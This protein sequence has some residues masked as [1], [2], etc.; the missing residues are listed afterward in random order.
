MLLSELFRSFVPLRNPIGFG[1]SD[2]VELVFA[3]LLVL[4]ALAWRPWIEPH[5]ARLAQRAGWCMLALAALPVVLRLLLLPQHPLPLPQISD[6]FSHLL[7]ADTLRHFRLANSTHPLHQFFETLDVLQEPSYGSIYPI[8]QGAVLALGWMIFGHPWAGAMLSVAAFCALCY[9]MLRG[10]TTPGWA[11]AGGLLA[12]FE[13]GPLNEWM[14]GYWG[15]G[16]SAAAGCLVFGAMPRLLEGKPLESKLG[17]RCLARDALLLGLGLAVQWLVRPYEFILLAASA[18]LFFLPELRKV[19]EVRRKPANARKPARVLAAVALVMLPAAS[20]TLIQNKQATGSWSTLPYMLSRHQYGVPTTFATQPNPVPHRKLTPQQQL[21]YKMQVSF[22]GKTA[23]TIPRFLERL[24]YRMRF[25]R[26]F[27]FAP[28]YLV[29]PAFLVALREWRFAWVALCL[30]IFA[31]GANLY[32]FFFPHYIAAGTCLFVLVSVTGLE[33]LYR[34]TI[35]GVPAGQEAAQLILLL[36]AA[37]FA[38]WYGLHLFD[39]QPFSMDL[40]QYETWDGLNHGDPVGRTAIQ[41]ALAEVPG[42]QLVFVHYWP[43]HIFQQEWVYNAA[44]ID[45]ARVVWARDLGAV[46]NHKLLRYYPDRTAWLLEPDARPPKLGR[47][48]PAPVT[49]SEGAP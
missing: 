13:F 34:L 41:R 35:R 48:E 22:H 33:R 49:H 38:F 12:V 21:E 43:Q 8:G 42:K 29:L 14:N 3:A 24:E 27:F 18:L 17:E 32:P 37:H 36:C 31:L 7:A 28:L 25:Y 46:E 9:W 10:W 19:L 47:Y 5:A 6:E 44:D 45:G 30:L 26:F 15:G 1:A 4:P 2:F 40:R 23:E 20:I 11:L 39:R 16:V